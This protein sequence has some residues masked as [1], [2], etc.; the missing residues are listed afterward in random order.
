M[1]AYGAARTILALGSEST[2]AELW[3]LVRFSLKYCHGKLNDRGVVASDSDEL[4]NRFPSGD[5]NL[6]T[7]TLYYDALLSASYI[8]EQLGERRTAALYRTRAGRLKE[9]ISAHFG[10]CVEGYDTYRYYDGNDVLRSWICMPLVVGITDRAAGTVEALL[11]PRLMTPDGLLTQSGTRTFW[12][13]STLYALRG[14]FATGETEKATAFLEHYAATRLLGEHVPYPIEAWPEGNQRHL[15][16]ESG[17][18]LP[19][20]HRG[21]LRHP[22]HGLQQFRTHTAAAREVGPHGTRKH[23]RFRR[24]TLR[25]SGK[26]SRG[27]GSTCE[28]SGRERSSVGKSSAAGRPC[29]S[30][31]P[32]SNQER[33][34]IRRSMPSATCAASNRKA[35]ERPM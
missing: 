8:A 24:R 29:A 30:H 2:A 16:A 21:D 19:H 27:S 17:A 23:I 5:A 20:L 26:P 31:C 34:R 35:S 28:S 18:L 3:P 15:S 22:A 9:C 11:S 10:A 12:D 33:S 7:S 4:E 6:C 13:R 25:Y 32:A 1:V 14:I